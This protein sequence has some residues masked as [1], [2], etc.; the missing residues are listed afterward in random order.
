M[1]E[2][3]EFNLLQTAKDAKLAAVAL[4]AVPAEKKTAALRSMAD[5]LSRSGETIFTANRQDVEDAKSVGLSDAKI[6]RLTLNQARLDLMCEGLRQVAD[7]R[8]PIGEVIDGWVR[9]NGLQ[10]SRVRVP[11]G[12]IGII[13]ESRPNVT[14]DAAALCIKSGNAVILRG[15]SESLRS[16]TALVKCLQEALKLTGIPEAAVSFVR[17]TDRALVSEMAGLNGI[18]DCIIPRGGAALIKAVI[19]NA[20]V[21][22]IETGT[23]N[24]HIYV[25]KS[26]DL[27]MAKEI[28]IN[29]K[30]QRPSVCNSAES[31]LIH[32]AVA[33]KFVP[34]IAAALHSKAVEIRGDERFVQLANFAKPAGEQ[35]WYEEYSD[36]IIAAKV[37]DSTGDAIAH[38]NK[39]GTH[40]SDSIITTSYADSQVFVNTVDSA[41]VYVNASTRFTDGYEFGF[42]AEIGI[43]NQKLHARGPMGLTELT[44]Y[45]YIIRGNGQIRD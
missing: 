7:L 32:S 18:I 44:T 8:D 40:H 16:N 30:V 36:L 14:V 45:K 31:M 24:C 15:G 42:G 21:P 29:A 25:D 6:E 12:L 5:V 28:I 19:K 22:V 10:L 2:D 38:I 41:A 4:A 23:G 43:S 20:R 3:A 9:P 37:V 39:Y 1:S 17:S 33:D 11:L 35:D 27:N 13:Y 26:A 34:M